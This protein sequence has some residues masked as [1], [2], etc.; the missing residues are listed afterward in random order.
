MDALT[1][2]L[3]GLSSAHPL[4]NPDQ[5]LSQPID[6]SL[7]GLAVTCLVVIGGLLWQVFK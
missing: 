7:L 2:S 6:A 5:L 1:N 3:Q 4:L